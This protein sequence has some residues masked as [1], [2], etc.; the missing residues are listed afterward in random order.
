M[1]RYRDRFEMYAAEARREDRFKIFMGVLMI[2][3]IIVAC[4]TGVMSCRARMDAC[5]KAGI[6]FW[7]CFDDSTRL[8]VP[9]DDGADH[10]HD[11]DDR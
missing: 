3:M 5:E 2:V 9:I 1:G 4:V 10:S 6:S 8:V 7:L 11:A